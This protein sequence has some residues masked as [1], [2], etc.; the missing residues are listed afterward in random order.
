MVSLCVY[1]K[2]NDVNG[3]REVVNF[4]LVLLSGS[5]ICIYGTAICR[6]SWARNLEV[7]L[8]YVGSA[9]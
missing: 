8:K 9:V 6:F 1:L 4:I 7:M 5:S 3:G 2:I